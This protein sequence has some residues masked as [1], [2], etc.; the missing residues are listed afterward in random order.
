MALATLAVSANSA[1]SQAS[2]LTPAA[3][4]LIQ[5]DGAPAAHLLARINAGCAEHLHRLFPI[6]RVVSMSS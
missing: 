4:S 3:V 6:R 5:R 1:V 2:S